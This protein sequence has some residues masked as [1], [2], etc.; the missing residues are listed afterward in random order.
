MQIIYEVHNK[1]MQFLDERHY[2]LKFHLGLDGDFQNF[3]KDY[4]S[5]ETNNL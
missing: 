5:F 2:C 3:S 4:R 1:A